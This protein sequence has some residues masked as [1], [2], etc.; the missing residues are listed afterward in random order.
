MTPTPEQEAL[1]K[2]D[3][4]VMD[5]GNPVKGLLRAGFKAAG[6]YTGKAMSEYT[7]ERAADVAKRSEELG[8]M[9]VKKLKE[10][11]SK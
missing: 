2:P 8:Q 9:A 6:K 4:D 11:L 3:I 7:A 10:G 1:Q 5:V